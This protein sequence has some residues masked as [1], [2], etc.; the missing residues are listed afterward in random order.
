MHQLSQALSSPPGSGKGRGVKKHSTSRELRKLPFPQYHTQAALHSRD[1]SASSPPTGC[2]R[3][4]AAVDAGHINA[5]TQG[6]ASTDWNRQV[7]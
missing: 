5:K 1:H 7:K 6:H 4:N 3:Y 2:G